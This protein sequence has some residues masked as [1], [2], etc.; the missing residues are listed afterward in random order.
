LNNTITLAI[1]LFA[2]IFIGFLAG[3][4]G[5]RWVPMERRELVWLNVFVIYFAI[6][7]LIFRLIAA[8]PVEQLANWG[9]IAGTTI[10][11]Y[12]VFVLMFVIATT[13]GGVRVAPASL[14]AA[15]AS[16]GNVGYMGV[17]LAVAVFGDA[18]AIPATLIVSFDSALLF[19]IVPVLVGL[20]RGEDG[21]ASSLIGAARSVALNP[22]IIALVAGTLVAVTGISL[23]GVLGDIGGQ[24]LQSLGAAAAPAALFGI[25]I[26][27]ARQ[28]GTRSPIHWEVSIITMIKLVVHPFILIVVLALLGEFDPV[29]VSVAI[30]L[31]ALPTAANVYVMASQFDT[32]TEGTSN[33]ILVTTTLSLFTLPVVMILMSEGKIPFDLLALFP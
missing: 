20:S 6:P 24:I 17:P 1:P 3:I 16:Y 33:A 15:S 5:R 14:Q 11:T 26:T 7:A 8:A 4:V 23:P 32:Y 28:Y 19:V 31:A 27:I 25:G 9:F 10:S 22:L 2:F 18:G 21:L 13:I 12:I 29:W 30:L